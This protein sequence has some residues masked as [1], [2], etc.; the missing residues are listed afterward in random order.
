MTNDLTIYEGDTL[1][2]ML[3]LA[4]NLKGATGLVPEHL[5]TEGQ[6]LATILAGRELGIGPMAAMR[7]LHVVKGKVG[8]DYSLWVA[9]LKRHGYRVEWLASGAEKASLRLTAPDGS[10]HTETWDK[11]RAT[12]A[13]LWGVNTWKAYPEAML[14]AR[15]VTSAGRAFAAEVMAGAYTVEEV[16]EIRTAEAHVL[17]E[18][19]GT[20]RLAAR[21]G[22]AEV[23]EAVNGETPDDLNAK[24]FADILQRI[25]GAESPQ[26]MRELADEI[27]NLD[28]VDYRRKAAEVHRQKVEQLRAD[29]AA[30]VQP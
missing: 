4:R 12:K 16:E 20:E 29:T 7:G 25:D 14:R 2:Q 9:Q 19:T 15:C 17:D 3:E 10:Q 5:K 24:M 22:V 13:G 27:K 23:A 11:E 21:L 28:D 1:R 18:R 6:I 26:Q 8:A 30:E